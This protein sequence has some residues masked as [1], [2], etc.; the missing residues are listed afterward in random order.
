[1]VWSPTAV[2]EKQLPKLMSATVPADVPSSAAGGG[3]ASWRW[4]YFCLLER[5]EQVLV[6]QEGRSRQR[7]QRGLR[8]CDD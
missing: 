4:G 7:K 2:S 5:D 8:R 3:E 6:R 1:M